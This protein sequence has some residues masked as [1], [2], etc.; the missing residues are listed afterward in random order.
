MIIFINTIIILL[1][2]F[3][4]IRY[5]NDYLNIQIHFK[6]D[7]KKG[8]LIALNF[9]KNLRFGCCSAAAVVLVL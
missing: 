6:N 5:L 7:C 2:L 3:L 8:K 4:L 1:H 9:Y